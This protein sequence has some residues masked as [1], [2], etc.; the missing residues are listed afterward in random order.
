MV[1]V[2]LG[3]G[4]AISWGVA[5]L[6]GGLKSRQLGV[7][8][9]LAGSQVFGA[10]L[11]GA[12]VVARGQGPP[13]T[14]YLV[15]GVLGGLSGLAALAAFYRGMAVGAMSVVAPISATGAAIPVTVGIATG[16]RPAAIQA[17]GLVL[18]LV[19]IRLVSREGGGNVGAKTAAGTGLALAAA[20]GFG[21]FFVGMDAASD[22]D[23]LWPLLASRAC[24]VVLLV[25]VFMVARPGVT[26]RPPDVRDVIA[27]GLFEVAANTLFAVASR[28]GLVSLVAVLAS[29]YPVATIFLARLVLKERIHRV[30]GVGVALAIAGVAAIAA[31]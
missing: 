15:Y 26:L 19:G 25:A 1:A 14:Q 4:A 3:L 21:G 5:D 11:I 8:T 2:A 6:L 10:L 9:V 30:Q 24:D 17:L 29:F 28:E 27:I 18:A 13:A 16:D 20:L 22:G 23:V 7:L 12:M 31:G